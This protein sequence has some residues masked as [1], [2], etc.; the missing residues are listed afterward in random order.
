MAL[1]IVG[2]NNMLSSSLTQFTVM[3]SIFFICPKAHQILGKFVFSHIGDTQVLFNLDNSLEEEPCCTCIT[4]QTYHLIP[5]EHSIV[6]EK[7]CHST[8]VNTLLRKHKALTICFLYSQGTSQDWLCIQSTL[9][10]NNYPFHEYG[11]RST[12]KQSPRMS[13]ATRMSSSKQTVSNLKVE[14]YIM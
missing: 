6:Q 2:H 13:F 10:F 8:M 3:G 12:T 7:K 5:G 9:N 14:A 11:A 1:D 4:N